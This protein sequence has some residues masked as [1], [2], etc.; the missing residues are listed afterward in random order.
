MIIT[1]LQGGLGN[2]LFQ[3][4]LGRFLS[5]K[6]NVPL[7]LD[8]GYYQNDK[9]RE[10]LLN[11]FMISALIATEEEIKKIK[12]E[13]VFEKIK[14]LFFK[15]KNEQETF[16]ESYSFN[17]EV[18]NLPDNTYLEGFWQ[19]EKYFKDIESIIRKEIVLKES[20]PFKANLLI[21]L[22]NNVNS[23]SIH[24][25]RGDYI[26]PKY[27][28]IFYP[29]TIE[30]YQKAI[31]LINKKVPNTHFFIFSDDIEWSKTLFFPKNITYVDSSY[32]LKD[33]QELM[34]MS[35]C[36]HNITTNS[37]FSWWAAWL[38]SNQNKIVITPKKWSI[39]QSVHKD[40]IPETW[41]KL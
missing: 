5:Y 21:E 8:I 12:S 16:V 2:Q 27:Q 17:Q 23:V 19:N 40:L 34:V 22:I 11:N 14:N 3:Y 29:I 9:K 6:L 20:L 10:C 39:Y 13:S 4:A 26:L 7:K 37:T 35:L 38:N 24:I 36:K 32:G 41:I 33:F 31:F 30:Y 15:R 28:K 18:L 1:K 25:R